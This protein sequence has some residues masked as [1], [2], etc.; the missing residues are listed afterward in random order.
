MRLEFVSPEGV[1]RDRPFAPA[2][3]VEGATRFLFISGQLGEDADGA[4][5]SAGAG[6]QAAQC[7]R[8]IDVLLSAAGAKKEDVAKLTIYLTH[9]ADREAVARARTDYFG[10]HTPATTGIVVAE[11]VVPGAIVEVEAL[12]T[13]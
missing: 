3:R 5:V 13:F 1:L 8:N 4:L 7:F 2:V 12:A 11:L 6:E 9:L 10:D